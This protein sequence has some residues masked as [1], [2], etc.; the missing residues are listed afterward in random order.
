MTSERAHLYLV[1]TGEIEVDFRCQ[2]CGDNVYVGDT[3]LLWYDDPLTL[4]ERCQHCIWQ[5]IV[6]MEESDSG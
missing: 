4:G 5:S 1:E 2:Q 6:D 3:A